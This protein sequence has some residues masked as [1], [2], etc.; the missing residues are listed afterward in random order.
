MPLPLH[1]AV[2]K[3]AKRVQILYSG[4]KVKENASTYKTNKLFVLQ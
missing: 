2:G 3:G 4:G 1:G